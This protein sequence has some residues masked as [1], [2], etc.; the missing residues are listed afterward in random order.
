MRP[1]VPREPEGGDEPEA[2]EPDEHEHGHDIGLGSELDR[3]GEDRAG[4][5]RPKR[6]AEVGDA[7]RKTQRRTRT[8]QD[9]PK[10]TTIALGGW[11]AR[12]GAPTK[13][14][15]A[16]AHRLHLITLTRDRRAP[17][18]KNAYIGADQ[19]EMWN[20]LPSLYP[21]PGAGFSGAANALQTR[22]WSAG[23]PRAL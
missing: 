9:R 19:H 14:R 20:P 16:G 2:R 23:A 6:R 11:P 4:D 13:P 18:E 8:N 17:D 21:N 15:G 10:P 12:L 5:R 1:S 3:G 7:S 22:G